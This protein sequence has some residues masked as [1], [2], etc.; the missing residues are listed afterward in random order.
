MF[1]KMKGFTQEK[2]YDLARKN[3]GHCPNC[4]AA[5]SM[6]QKL[7]MENLFCAE[8]FW[9]GSWR[10]LE[11]GSGPGV[12]LREKPA[13]CK[14]TEKEFPDG[15]EWLIP[16]KKRINFLLVFGLLFGGF[17]LLLLVF[18]LI[19]GDFDSELGMLGMAAFLSIFIF[20]GAGV[21]YI[22]LRLA[23]TAFF[24]S[25]KNDEAILIRKFFGRKKLTQLP[26]S[27]F[28]GVALYES[29]RSNEVPVYGLMLRSRDGKSLKFGVSLKEDE[30]RWLGGRI[31][32]SLSD[33]MIATAQKAE[34]FVGDSQAEWADGTPE[35]KEFRGVRL[36]RV[37]DGFRMKV[38]ASRNAKGLT[39]LGVFLLLFGGVFAWIGFNE[40]GFPF[41]IAGLA[42]V[43]VG[44]GVLARV[45]WTLGVLR[46][47]EFGRDGLL[48]KNLRRSQEKSRTQ[49][50]R[51]SFSD[52][53]VKRIGKSNNSPRFALY[54]NGQKEVKIFG[55]IESEIA[56][57]VT[58]WLEWWLANEKPSLA[59]ESSARKTEYAAPVS[60]ES[61]QAR[62]RNLRRDHLPILDASQGDLTDSKAG[63][64]G[65][66]I[67]M[68]LLCTI[69]LGLLVF[70]AAQVKKGRASVAWPT[71]EGEIMAAEMT[72]NRGDSTTYGAKIIYA[73]E[74]G[75]TG[76]SGDKVSLG[77]YS[78]SNSEH[79]REI[80][81][82]Y[83]I[84]KKVLVYYNPED[85]SEAILEP[86]IRGITWILLGV[87][88]V[89]FVAALI[90]L[91]MFEQ[92]LRKKSREHL[93]SNA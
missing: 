4:G 82:R 71:T 55:W 76:F 45:V 75:K 53:T 24:L 19:G 44:I 10:A 84:G 90:S 70:G 2:L 26:A 57:G 59:A 14:I 40:A 31:L 93:A 51:E 89:L 87:G 36:E 83:P 12:V 58:H 80:L 85:P 48:F 1:E 30:K 64:W 23:F 72:G 66:R 5:V 46:V 28:L 27:D 33:E 34:P 42:V 65:A 68:A 6:P 43:V 73:Y 38:D 63:R 79:A 11:S 18:S 60:T 77:D 88:A 69:G 91:L 37:A 52:V 92:K 41:N 54:L 86:G 22:G 74:L 50:A 47:Y 3:E 15:R 7:P 67:F 62:A 56:Q 81:R 20:I 78:S 61:M 25:V 16:S 49:F 17:P 32:E 39:A 35:K 8:C 29:H 13:A 9:R 21:F